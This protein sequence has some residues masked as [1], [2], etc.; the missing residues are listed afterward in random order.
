[1]PL[2]K[3]EEAGAAAEAPAAISATSA[4]AGW[5]RDRVAVPE[6]GFSALSK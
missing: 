2:P 4:A 1:M 5:K 6:E 3:L